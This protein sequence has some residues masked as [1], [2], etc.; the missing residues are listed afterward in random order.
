[1]EREF[2]G[3]SGKL[4]GLDFYT[5]SSIYK[6]YKVYM[7]KTIRLSDQIHKTLLSVLGDIQSISEERVTMDKTIQKLIEEWRNN[8][9]K[10]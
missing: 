9:G 3:H 6:I 1:M 7:V 10:K 5:Q 8:H 4:L 2:S